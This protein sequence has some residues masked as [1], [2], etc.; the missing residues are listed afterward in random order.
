ME[1]IDFA[2][3]F[4]FTGRTAIVTGAAG[5]I[6]REIAQLFNERGIRMALVDRDPSIVALAKEFSHG[7]RGWIADITNEDDIKQIVQEVMTAFGRID[8]L[9]NSAAIGH[10]G[11][12]EAIAMVNGADLT[13]GGYTIRD[14]EGSTACDA[15]CSRARRYRWSADGRRCAASPWRTLP[16]PA[17]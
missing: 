16:P 3:T 17:R 4:D 1:R 2:R 7:T 9:V 12:A 13:D 14:T 15:R 8:I 10:V 6:G 5:G 11:A